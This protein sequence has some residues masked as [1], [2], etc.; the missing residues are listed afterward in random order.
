MTTQT[1]PSKSR[2]ERMG[3]AEGHAIVLPAKPQITG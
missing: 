2:R 1:T 3:E